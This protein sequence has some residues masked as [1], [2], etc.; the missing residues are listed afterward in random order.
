[1]N[2][3]KITRRDINASFEYIRSTFFPRR[4]RQHKWV[5]VQSKVRPNSGYCD[6]ESMRIRI[7]P[8]VPNWRSLDELMTHEITH[9]AISISH[10]KKFIERLEK[11]AL[12]AEGIGR[13]DLV[14]EIRKNCE[15][16]FLPVIPP[17]TTKSIRGDIEDIVRDNRNLVP[18]KELIAMIAEFHGM[19]CRELPKKF[20]KRKL[21]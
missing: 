11:T 9:A 5:A 19:T 10:S 2:D 14:A 20:G 16:C 17:L 4:N 13:Q 6:T 12:K 1:M 18:F 3:N 8:S 7:N 15:E 21:S